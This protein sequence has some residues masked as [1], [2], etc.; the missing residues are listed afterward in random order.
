MT[1]LGTE[2]SKV[3]AKEFPLEKMVEYGLLVG[4]AFLLLIIAKLGITFSN[5]L[6]DRMLIPVNQAYFDRN[7]AI[8]VSTLLKSLIMYVVYAMAGISILGMFNVPLQGV[9]TGA[10]II[11]LA[12][13]FGGQSLVKDVITGFFIIFENQFTVGEYIAMAGVSGIVEEVGLRTTKI[14]DFGGQLHIVPNGQIS[15]VT[16]YNR[17]SMRALV[18]VG[19]AFEEDLDQAVTVLEE[20]CREV[21]RDLAEIITETPQVLGV[22]AFGRAA[23]TLRI[24]AKTKPMEQ[25]RVERELRK[26]ITLAFNRWGIEMPYLK[27]MFGPRKGEKQL[28]FRL[29]KEEVGD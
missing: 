13:G 9:L 19:I 1:S 15:Q 17:G 14:R 20:V 10:G 21:N 12:V 16:N 24:I 6:I 5:A 26:R 7:R 28:D 29:G 25:W 3:L 18:D 27:G 8:T 11:G 22:Q 4:K 23:L 2:L